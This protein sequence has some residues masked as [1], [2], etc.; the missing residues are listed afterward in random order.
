MKKIILSSFILVLLSCTESERLIDLD[1][2]IE[3]A[4]SYEMEFR[5]QTDSIKMELSTAVCDS[6]RFKYAWQLNERYKV[7]NIDTCLMYANIML[8][9]A[10]TRKDTII[11]RSA[12]VYALA[13]I[14]HVSQAEEVLH[15][16]PTDF[17]YEPELNIY[18]E[19]A[20]HLYFN[21]P[22]FTRDKRDSCRMVR[23]EIREAML[24]HDSTS[25]IAKTYLIHEKT[26]IKDYPAAKR[27]A[28]SILESEDIPLRHRGINEYN[29]AMVHKMCNE[30]E[31]AKKHLIEAALID[32]STSTKEYNS[33]Y[34]LAKILR[35]E[36]D[37]ER[38]C[39]YMLQTLNDAIFCNYKDHYQRSAGASRVIYQIYE[40]ESNLKKR[41]QNQLFTSLIILLLT[42]LILLAVQQVYSR[43]VK[44]ANNLLKV[45]NLQLKDGNLIRDHILS[46]YMEKSVFYIEKVDENKSLMRKTYRK[47]GLE[48]LLKILR[49]PSF[50][51]TE[52]KNYF[53]DFDRSIIDLFPNFVEDVNSL[54]KPENRILC[55]K[56][57]ALSTEMRIL[58]LIRLGITE[59]PQ[60]AKAL[61][62]SIRTTYC[63]RYKLRHGAICPPEQ[64]DEK[65]RAI[66]LYS[67]PREH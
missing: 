63:Y 37:T 13:S 28:R 20:H 52:F 10:T 23:H 66:G 60:I 27:V 67:T 61:N 29:L 40:H 17:D 44:K 16:I 64:F 12:L 4:P 5:S 31:E 46:K 57:D 54:L 25:Y 41:R 1:K 47:E 30:R 62:I 32:L 43:K 55:K 36:G 48:A 24:K 9:N 3:L 2:T 33:L 58:A 15:S 19:S 18:Y 38:A 6:C 8:K 39:R 42:T 59:S 22:K 7:Y 51:D 56:G 53:Q 50:A 21:I 34:D 65:I 14:G 49:S 11:A 35:D 26:F 45:S